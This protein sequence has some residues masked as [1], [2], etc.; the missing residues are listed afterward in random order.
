M[1]DAINRTGFHRANLLDINSFIRNTPDVQKICAG[2]DIL[3][4]YRY[5]YGPILSAVQYWK[6][7]DKKVIVDFDQAINYLTK[8]K[9]GYSF[10]FD[11]VPLEV[12]PAEENSRIDPIPLEQFKWG[13]GMVDAATVPSGRL[14]DDWAQFTD[15]YQIPDYINTFQYPGLNQFHE[16]EIWMG[17][18]SSANNDGFEQSGLLAAMEGICQENPQVKLVIC[19]RDK[20]SVMDMKI[21]P[22]QMRIYS[23]RTFDE[24][25]S[26]LLK[27]DIG[28]APTSGDYDLRLGPGS[29]L[30]F[31]VSKIP[32]IASEPITFHDISQYARFVQNTKDEWK[33]AILTTLDQLSVYQKKAAGDPFLFAISQD[34]SANIEKVLKVY[35]S[36]IN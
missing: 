14:A 32:V 36:I 2:S 23:P 18:G 34:V 35:G 3:V 19:N 26:V 24:W 33:I 6:A 11:G 12:D 30:E 7:R 9:P 28:L 20:E 5:L 27:L 4:I 21:A 16:D 8:N 22:S 1:A 31:M 15:I 29:M 13:L 17:L 25:V 10:W